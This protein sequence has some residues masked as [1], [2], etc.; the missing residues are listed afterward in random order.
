M[1]RQ[2]HHRPETEYARRRKVTDPNPRW[3]TEDVVDLD[4]AMP[5]RSTPNQDDPN[6]MSKIRAILAMD[7]DEPIKKTASSTSSATAKRREGKYF[8][9]S[10]YST[11]KSKSRSTNE[12]PKHDEKQS[13]RSGRR[14]TVY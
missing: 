12:D 13:R 1:T 9:F 8:N 6:T 4:I 3:R 5:T 14:N 11:G 2:S 10:D 7:L